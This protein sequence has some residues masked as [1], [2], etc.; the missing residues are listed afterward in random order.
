M[1]LSLSSRKKF[2]DTSGVLYSCWSSDPLVIWKVYTYI[3]FVQFTAVF[4]SLN[5]DLRSENYWCILDSSNYLILWWIKFCLDEPGFLVYAT[6]QLYNT[7]HQNMK[8]LTRTRIR[9][10]LH[11]YKQMLNHS[12]ITE[13]IVLQQMNSSLLIGYLRLVLKA[14]IRVIHIYSPP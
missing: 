13:I 11:N 10:A 6:L 8:M 14:R 3:R 2:R 12:K 9:H 7:T 1:I 5:A 4:K